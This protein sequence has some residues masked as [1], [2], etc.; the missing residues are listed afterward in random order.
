MKHWTIEGQV[1]MQPIDNTIK[2]IDIEISNIEA[3]DVET[4]IQKAKGAVPAL[5]ITDVR[6]A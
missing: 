5:Q 1:R 6:M 3:P 2:S 4:A